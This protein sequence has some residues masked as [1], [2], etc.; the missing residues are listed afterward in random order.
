MGDGWPPE[1]EWERRHP[2]SKASA[3][4]RRSR[5]ADLALV[6]V[7]ERRSLFLSWAQKSGTYDY[8][9]LLNMGWLCAT[10]PEGKLGWWEA[11]MG[12]GSREAWLKTA[13]AAS[14]WLKS[15]NIGARDVKELVEWQN[16]TG[17]LVNEE[18]NIVE[19]AYELFNSPGPRWRIPEA[20]ARD[21]IRQRMSRWVRP[22]KA[23]WNFGS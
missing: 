15:S 22:A 2:I 3:S 4:I 11:A 20:F 13:K 21:M 19:A 18:F 8:I 9:W 12:W 10:L 14:N 23:S 7:G 6:L 5:F 1:E 17:F 16:L